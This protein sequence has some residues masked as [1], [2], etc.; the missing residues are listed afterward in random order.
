MA[1]LRFADPHLRNQTVLEYHPLFLI[2]VNRRQFDCV[3]VDLQI[4]DPDP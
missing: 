4:S 1:F 2:E 3:S